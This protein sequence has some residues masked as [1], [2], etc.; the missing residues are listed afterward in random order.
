MVQQNDYDIVFMDHMMPDMDGVEAT[1]EIR[2]LGGKHE[3]LPIIALTAN[4]V[5]GAKEMFLANGFD[6]FI[7]KPIDLYELNETLKEWLPADKIKLSTESD[8]DAESETENTPDPEAS[9]LDLISDI[10]EIDKEAGLSHVDGMED[11]YQM[12]LE[13]F[14]NNLAPEC[15]NMSTLLDNGDIQS[16]AIAIHGTKSML[17]TIGAMKLSETALELE[18]AAKRGEMDYCLT[19][20]PVILEKLQALHK[21]LSAIFSADHQNS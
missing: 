11:I 5:Y 9:F 12:T 2:K 15:E 20:Y 16:F 10:E 3:T 18:L 13:L 7:S 19:N 14:S 4:A 8:S 1:A 21:R 6:G 17:S